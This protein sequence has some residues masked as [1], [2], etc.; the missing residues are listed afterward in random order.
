MTIF[1][2]YVDSN[3]SKLRKKLLLGANEPFTKKN[4]QKLHMMPSINKILNIIFSLLI[5]DII[6]NNIYCRKSQVEKYK[7]H[8]IDVNTPKRSIF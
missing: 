4:K 3:F 6:S 2:L 1:C 5:I 7:Y 8:K